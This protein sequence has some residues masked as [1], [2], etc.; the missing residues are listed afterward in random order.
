[1]QPAILFLVATQQNKENIASSQKHTLSDNDNSLNK[2]K[3]D[4]AINTQ[5]DITSKKRKIKICYREEY[6][7]KKWRWSDNVDYAMTQKQ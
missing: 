5:N 4:E 2:N 6:N 3:K 1:M 7:Y